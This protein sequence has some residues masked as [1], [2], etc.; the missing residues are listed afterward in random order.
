MLVVFVLHLV[1]C[2]LLPNRMNSVFD[3]FILSLYS[4][5]QLFIVSAHSLSPRKASTSMFVGIGL[6]R[7]YPLWSFGNSYTEIVG[8]MRSIKC[9]C[10]R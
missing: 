2:V 8:G 4:V 3:V 6:K 7:L 9:P 5:T 10:M 1:R